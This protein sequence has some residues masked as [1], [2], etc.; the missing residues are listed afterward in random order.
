M[1]CN[2]TLLKCY[3]FIELHFRRLTLEMPVIRTNAITFSH[4]TILEKY[5]PQTRV[6]HRKTKSEAKMKMNLS[7]TKKNNK[8]GNQ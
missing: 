6:K 4:K 1:A 2:D 8:K 3:F 7:M 5:A